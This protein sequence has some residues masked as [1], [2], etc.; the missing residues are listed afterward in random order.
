M[1]FNINE[2]FKLG[3][4]RDIPEL[5]EPGKYQLN[6]G[7]GANKLP[8]CENIDWPDWDAVTSNIPYPSESMDTIWAFHFFEHL[9]GEDAIRILKECERVLVVGGT[10]NIVVPHRLGMIAYQDL[11]HKSFWTEETIRTLVNNPYY[12]KNREVAWQLQVHMGVIIGIVERN[13]ALMTQ[14]VKGYS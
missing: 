3:M 13:L 2:F 6:L 9:T 8:N 1:S 12:E 7:C 10:L 11:D 14:L 4:K 5:I